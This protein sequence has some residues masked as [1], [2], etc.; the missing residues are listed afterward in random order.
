MSNKGI[1]LSLYDTTKKVNEM[2]ATDVVQVPSDRIYFEP[3]KNPVLKP[4]EQYK[5]VMTTD[6]TVYDVKEILDIINNCKEE[7]GAISRGVYFGEWFD[8]LEFVYTFEIDT[9]ATDGA[10]LFICP[11]WVRWLM[12]NPDGY[13]TTL[14]MATLV[15]EVYHNIW[16]HCE[17]ERQ[18]REKNMF[19]DHE[20]CNI[21]MDYEIDAMIEKAYPDM[22]KRGY[23][24]NDWH[25][26]LEDCPFEIDPVSHKILPVR[27]Q[28]FDGA[29]ATMGCCINPDF[30][31]YGWTDIYKK[32]AKLPRNEWMP[33]YPELKKYWEEK[34]QE[35]LG[36]IDAKWTP[37]E[38]SGWTDGW[39][40]ELEN[41]RKMGIVAESMDASC[42]TYYKC[43][44]EMASGSGNKSYDDR[45]DMARCAARKL[46]HD[47]LT[48]GVVLPTKGPGP[49]ALLP[50]YQDMDDLY[51]SLRNAQSTVQ[52]EQNKKANDIALKN[53]QQAALA[54]GEEVP[55][56][57]EDTHDYSDRDQ[58]INDVKKQNFSANIQAYLSTID[59]GKE[60]FGIF[61]LPPIGKGGGVGRGP[62][63]FPTDIIDPIKGDEFTKRAGKPPRNN[64]PQPDSDT[65]DRTIKEIEDNIREGDQ[66]KYRNTNTDILQ[67]SKGSLHDA[68]AT[69][70]N[71]VEKLQDF[72]L[73]G[74]PRRVISKKPTSY[75]GY[76]IKK[77]VIQRTG[78]DMAG[79]IVV[80]LDTSFSV[81]STKN[82]FESFV[83]VVQ[84]IVKTVKIKYVDLWLFDDYV[85]GM[86]AN[87]HVKKEGDS[88]DFKSCKTPFVIKDGEYDQAKLNAYAS[89]IHSGCTFYDQ[90]F[91][92]AID[93]YFCEDTME[94]MVDDD[95]YDENGE[96]IDEGKNEP[97]DAIIIMTDCD[98][99][100]SF[101]N[102][103]K[104]SN[105]D[106]DICANN[107]TSVYDPDGEYILDEIDPKLFWCVFEKGGRHFKPEVGGNMFTND[108]R[109]LKISWT[110]VQGTF[111]ENK[112]KDE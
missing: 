7:I 48:S 32:L 87:C 66:E 74:M 12:S 67:K 30:F 61:P 40:D 75:L 47:A 50:K 17:A 100:C 44:F 21:A 83:R 59:P 81:C 52:S 96:L 102:S 46:I 77:T 65:R 62:D 98:L 26:E 37:D 13:G 5:K 27:V 54:K 34:E 101:I 6:G 76:P 111:D 53:A 1:V 56:G 92:H 4:F 10:H 90:I 104:N 43:L 109:Y 8:S 78:T 82:L 11:E 70:V 112:D 95:D 97:V 45:Y 107:D 106:T 3:Y 22:R 51:G 36:P 91:R 42:E 60:E 49:A 35:R 55:E 72:L 24:K 79:K 29:F 57:P 39:N 64:R 20:L 105:L 73:R 9:M 69:N 33:K 2:V 63:G 16:G 41:A 110:E 85:Y 88:V 71:W 94:Q 103:L 99:N 86:P 18:W 108:T 84:D 80:Y 25:G 28:I 58:M 31:G 93:R 15:H 19:M 68:A 38:K 14:V 23:G 89:Y